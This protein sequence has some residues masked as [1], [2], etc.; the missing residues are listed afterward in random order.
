MNTALKS[1]RQFGQYRIVGLL[2]RGGMGEVYEVEHTTLAR[3][4]A[5]KLLPPEFSGRPDALERFRREARVMAN[6]DHPHIVRVDDFGETEGRYWLRMELVKGV[7]LPADRSGDR[8][9]DIPVRLPSD[10]ATRADRNVRAPIITLA[11]YA[12]RRGGRL[13]Q[14]EFGLLLR[15]V[16]EAL[17]F[18]HDKGIVHRDLKPA[19]ILLERDAD[20]RV[21]AK[22]ADFGLARVVGDEFLRS[23]AER[24]LS[25]G[26]GRTLGA[27]QSLGDEA[28][29]DGEAGSARALVGTWE[30]MA[31]EQRRGEEADTRSDVYAAGLICYRLLTG[32]GLGLKLPSELVP[33]LDSRWDGLVSGAVEQDPAARYANGRGML[34]A[35]EPLL[36]GMRALAGQIA[37]ETEQRQAEEERHAAAEA[38]RLR[39]EERGRERKA[40]EQERRRRLAATLRRWRVGL[41]TALVS[42]WSL[43]GLGILAAGAAAYTGIPVGLRWAKARAERVAAE[44]ADR[45]RMEQ[46]QQALE[47]LRRGRAIAMGYKSPEEY[48]AAEARDAERTYALWYQELM[49]REPLAR[50][51]PSSPFTNSLGMRF[52]YIHRADLLFSIW[53]TRG[54]DYAAYAASEVGVDESWRKSR[55]ARDSDCPVAMVSYGDASGFCAWL[56]RKER[57]EGRIKRTQSYRLPTDSDWDCAVGVAGSKG[58]ITVPIGGRMV[59]LGYP[60]GSEWPPPRQA[61]NY[62]SRQVSPAG[63]FTAS[64]YGLHDLGG[65]VWEWCSADS[66]RSPSSSTDSDRMRPVNAASGSPVVVRGGSWRCSIKQ[67]S[68]EV[69]Q[70]S[71]REHRASSVRQDDIG[72]RVV[73]EDAAQTAADP[74]PAGTKSDPKTSDATDDLAARTELPLLPLAMLDQYQSKLEITEL[75]EWA[76]VKPLLLQVLLES[77]RAGTRHVPTGLQA[78]HLR[79]AVAA[80]AGDSELRFRLSAV[81][82]MSSGSGQGAKGTEAQERLR[83]VLT[84]RQE[85]IAVLAGLLP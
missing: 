6:L 43:A 55:S 2:G 52:V 20:G 18:A 70:S 4:Y 12:A 16:L 33:G 8:S 65:N 60:W 5:L 50:F 75:A 31:P 49:A 11:D 67:T 32:K 83:Q 41:R 77:R 21:L 28:T 51:T 54:K 37:I 45:R 42:R 56:T 15:Q 29:A 27:E 76:V 80:K 1:R 58:A 78:E 3:S 69:L 85:A 39:E 14:S 38:E 44:A 84:A 26:G 61:G 47:G 13:E 9:A 34:A 82:V 62:G 40:R 48:E 36:E 35:A 30:Y 73:L 81:R 7:E 57:A 24:S 71:H 22:V 72:F 64:Y 68:K 53:E 79:L 19:N 46:G 66:E 17:A 74:G 63:S 25:V 23:Q 10:A 59:T